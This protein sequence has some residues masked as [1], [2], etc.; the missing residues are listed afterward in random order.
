MPISNKY[1]QTDLRS[2]FTL[3]P[4]CKLSTKHR[5]SLY[6]IHSN[7]SFFHSFFYCIHTLYV[8]KFLAYLLFGVEINCISNLMLCKKFHS[9]FLD[10]SNTIYMFELHYI[11][12]Q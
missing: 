7:N 2:K 6:F 10:I 11:K 4:N 12:V 1:K 9:T 3:N 8:C 5:I